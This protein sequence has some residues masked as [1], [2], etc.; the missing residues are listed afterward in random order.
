ME[1]K[2][3][4]Y[5]SNNTRIG[6]TFERRARQLVRQQRAMWVDESQTAIRFAPGMEN[7]DI[8]PVGTADNFT[9]DMAEEMLMPNQLCFAPWHDHY[10]YPAVISD[11]LLNLVKVAFLDG[12]SGQAPPELVIGLQEGFDT[13]AFE[14]KYS[15]MGFYRGVIVSQQPIVF[16]YD[17]DGVVE[18]TELRMLRGLR[19]AYR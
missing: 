2:I 16:Q 7:M 6:E 19:G 14:C 13:M 4:L 10:Y 18:Y 3:T 12:S 5:N 11:V 9:D 8:H 17:E 1:N 15:W